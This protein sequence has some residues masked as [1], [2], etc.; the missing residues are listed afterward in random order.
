MNRIV[1]FSLCLSLMTILMACGNNTKA[2]DSSELLQHMKFH[3]TEFSFPCTYGVI[4]GRFGLTNETCNEIAG[5]SYTYYDL[6]YQENPV[7]SIGFIGGNTDQND[8]REI[9]M[10]VIEDE[11]LSAL[12]LGETICNAKRKTL[13]K[14]LGKPDY[15]MEQN[16]STIITYNW[17]NV[18]L[19]IIFHDD[20]PH[21]YTFVKR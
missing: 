18:D 20:Q 1:C 2:S 6:T 15:Q 9:A 14:A 8:N 5:N 3:D 21:Q 7:A 19:S 13:I 17:E 11:Q 12:E 16:Q 10:L 4:S